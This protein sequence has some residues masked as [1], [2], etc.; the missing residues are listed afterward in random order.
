L[1]Y[2]MRVYE[3]MPGKVTT[4][5]ALFRDHMDALFT[6][7]GFRAV[8][9]WTEAIGDN[10]LFN[11]M[12]AWDDS[13]QMEERWN[14]LRADPDFRGSIEASNVNGTVVA[15]MGTRVWRPTAFSPLP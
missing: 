9:Y 3:A 8:G 12:L 11:Y 1:I 13:S 2:E 14:A 4:L 7:H 6:K 10:T 5:Q 15:K